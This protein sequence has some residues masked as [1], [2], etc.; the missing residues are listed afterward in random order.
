[1]GCCFCCGGGGGFSPTLSRAPVRKGI[2]VLWKED[3]FCK[4][5]P[6][7]PKRP[8]S[9]FFFFFHTTDNNG[10]IRTIYFPPLIPWAMPEKK[11]KKENKREIEKTHIASTPSRS[12]VV[13]SSS[14]SRMVLLNASAQPSFLPVLRIRAVM[15]VSS[16]L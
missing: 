9:Q 8:N 6:P 10:D 1:M 11:R 12:C 2:A 13:I 14:R 4:L 15:S 3:C 7:S 16:A 5:F